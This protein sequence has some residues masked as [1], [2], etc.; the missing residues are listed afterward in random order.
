MPCRI[1]G[2]AFRFLISIAPAM[3][4]QRLGAYIDPRPRLDRLHLHSV[5]RYSRHGLPDPVPSPTDLVNAGSRAS[6]TLRTLVKRAG[7]LSSPQAQGLR[8]S[9]LPRVFIRQHT[10]ISSCAALAEAQ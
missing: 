8:I 3:G 9:R 7:S 1:V 4:C 5:L 6:D 10:R 2:K